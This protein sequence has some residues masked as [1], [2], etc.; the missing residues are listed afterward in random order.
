MLRSCF[1]EEVNA[2]MVNQTNDALNDPF[3]PKDKVQ[4]LLSRRRTWWVLLGFVP[5]RLSL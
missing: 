2:D 3:G 4:I 1:L 5:S